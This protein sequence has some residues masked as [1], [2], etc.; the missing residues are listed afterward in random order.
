MPLI[1]SL[2]STEKI[3]ASKVDKKIVMVS[4]AY[5]ELRGVKYAESTATRWILL[6]RHDLLQY[7]KVFAILWLSN[8]SFWKRYIC[9]SPLLS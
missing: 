7:V 3:P 4:V 8:G 2:A 9:P 1:F 6:N 5:F